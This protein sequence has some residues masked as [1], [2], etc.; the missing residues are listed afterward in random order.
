MKKR[1]GKLP[2]RPRRLNRRQSIPSGGCCYFTVFPVPFQCSE[3]DDRTS[4]GNDW[5]VQL[6]RLIP[7]TCSS[8]SCK[9]DSRVHTLHCRGSV[10][11][12][13]FFFFQLWKKTHDIQVTIIK[14]MGK[15]KKG[16][17]FSHKKEGNLA[18]CHN[19]EEPE[20]IVV[21]ETK[22]LYNTTPA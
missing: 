12:C 1:F 7:R 4:G 19:M 15:E 11:C 6:G 10:T 3:G 14:G 20:G 17:S 22:A 8:W 5:G 21:S 16:I 9:W 2:G 18:I 13:F